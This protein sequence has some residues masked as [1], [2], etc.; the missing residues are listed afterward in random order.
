MSPAVWAPKAGKIV[1]RVCFDGS[2]AS[3]NHPSVNES[4]ELTTRGAR[5]F[6]LPASGE[7]TPLTT[8]VDCELAPKLRHAWKRPR[9]RLR[10]QLA[11]DQCAYSETSTSV[12][13]RSN[14]SEDILGEST[15]SAR[16]LRN[17]VRDLAS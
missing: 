10:I 9:G 7:P 14:Q 16:S 17:A 6:D 5:A 2:K 8:T 3:R 1:G 13:H 4:T 11:A 15:T 12:T